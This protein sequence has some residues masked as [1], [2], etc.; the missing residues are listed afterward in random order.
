[1]LYVGPSTPAAV[2]PRSLRAGST[3]FETPAADGEG[4]RG[5]GEP[6]DLAGGC[7]RES[8]GEEIKGVRK[9]EESKL[10][11]QG[12]KHQLGVSKRKPRH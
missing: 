6:E 11:R 5:R 1:M 8:S 7:P 9:W 12:G 10:G 2:E 3:L 4:T